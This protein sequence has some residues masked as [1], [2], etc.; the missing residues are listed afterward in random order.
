MHIELGELS[1]NSDVSLFLLKPEHVT[2]EYVSWLNDPEVNQYLE[3]RFTKHTL[4]SSRNF[5]QSLL[6]SPENL[7]LG[8]RS[9]L[10]DRHVGNIKIGPIDENHGTGEMGIVIGD[11]KAWGKGIASSAVSLMVRIARDLHL[12]RK[13]FASYYSSHIASQRLFEKSGFEV[14]GVRKQH[15]LL[16]GIPEDD[17]VVVKF[18]K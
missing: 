17:V 3:C 1:S 4:E 11:K 13:I 2:Q 12:L 15:F 7:F 16:N 10:F 14:E 6:D 9:N 5:V 18:L 8:I